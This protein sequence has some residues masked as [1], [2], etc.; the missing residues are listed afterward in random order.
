MDFFY[1]LGRNKAL[2]HSNE[3]SF[4][5]Y[6]LLFFADNL[7]L[8]RKCQMLPQDLLQLPLVKKALRFMELVN[9]HAEAFVANSV[10]FFR[11]LM[12]EEIDIFCGAILED[13]FLKIRRNS[14]FCLSVALNAKNKLYSLSRLTQLLAF[15]T[16]EDAK[17]FCEYL[18]PDCFAKAA[19]KISDPEKLK[20]L[21]WLDPAV[22]GN[23]FNFNLE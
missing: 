22:I 10:E 16:T 14:V 5:A 11:L 3:A 12:D 2:H 17:Q 8:P 13:S 23:Q 1:K 4:R 19:G 15:E 6:H 9:V 7:D 20:D 18:D 21:V